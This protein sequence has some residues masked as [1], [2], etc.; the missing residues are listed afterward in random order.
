MIFVMH[1]DE[2]DHSD[3]TMLLLL[4]L[5]RFSCVQLCATPYTAAHQASPSLG[6]SRQEHWSGLPS[7]SSPFTFCLKGMKGQLKQVTIHKWMDLCSSSDNCRNRFIM[8]DLVWTTY[9][10]FRSTLIWILIKLCKTPDFQHSLYRN[11]GY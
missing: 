2:F 6:F 3:I 8:V 7:W 11:K 1:V 10:L 4:L 9:F 5:S